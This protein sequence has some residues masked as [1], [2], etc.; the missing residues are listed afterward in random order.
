MATI[1][2]LQPMSELPAWVVER[3]VKAGNCMGLRESIVV[4][5]ITE[6]LRIIEERG[7]RI[8]PV[9]STDLMRSVMPPVSQS[10]WA[11]MLGAAPPLAELLENCNE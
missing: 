5:G 9:E 11:F 1:D 6:F 3:C 7:L 8:V 10:C 2:Q 4:V